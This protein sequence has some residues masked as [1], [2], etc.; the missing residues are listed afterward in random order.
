MSSVQSFSRYTVLKF[1][2]VIAQPALVC[3]CLVGKIVIV[4]CDYPELA[5]TDVAS[6]TASY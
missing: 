6:L 1:E 3:D 4:I 5:L 2:G